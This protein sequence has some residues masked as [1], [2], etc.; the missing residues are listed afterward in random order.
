[1]AIVAHLVLCCMTVKNIC[2][3]LSWFV[4]DLRLSH[5]SVKLLAQ[6][7]DRKI[8]CL[9]VYYPYRGFLRNLSQDL[10]WLESYSL[11]FV[12]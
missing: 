6:A 1:M 10:E 12:L 11:V 9:C 4:G 2:V 5:L 3:F 8:H 7:F